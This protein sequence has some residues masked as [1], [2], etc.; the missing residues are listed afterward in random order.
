MLAHTNKLISIPSFCK[1]LFKSLVFLKRI[2]EDICG[3]IHPLCELFRYFMVLIDASIRWSH[4]CL[5]S[6]HNVAS[7]LIV[8]KSVQ[9]DVMR[10][11]GAS[12]AYSTS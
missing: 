8:V 12:D 7:G 5:L 9:G 2:H 4:V 1:I 6:T 10:H 3:P 11:V